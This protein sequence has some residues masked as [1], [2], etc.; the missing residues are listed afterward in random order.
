[1]SIQNG[2]F[3][4]NIN[5]PIRVYKQGRAVVGIRRAWL[6]NWWMQ[7]QLLGKLLQKWSRV[8]WRSSILKK[9]WRR[10]S[11]SCYQSRRK[12]LLLR[13][14]T[15]FGQLKLRKSLLHLLIWALTRPGWTF[16]IRWASVFALDCRCWAQLLGYSFVPLAPGAYD[17]YLEFHLDWKG[18][19]AVS[20]FIHIFTF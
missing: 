19:F 20:V 18:D 1:M 8:G 7:T 4:A 14:N 9:S 17:S 2:F 13:K 6:T 11:L 16:L 5:S 3:R 12:P 15:K 10:R